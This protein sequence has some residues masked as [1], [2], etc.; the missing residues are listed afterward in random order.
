[1]RLN[2]ENH[3]RPK[4]ASSLVFGNSVFACKGCPP[5]VAN[6]EQNVDLKRAI[7]DPYRNIYGPFTEDFE[8]CTIK[9]P[10]SILLLTDKPE[11]KPV[12]RNGGPT[13]RFDINYKINK[14]SDNL[15]LEYFLSGVYEHFYHQIEKNCVKLT[16]FMTGSVID[17]KQKMVKIS[18]LTPTLSKIRGT[19]DYFSKILSDTL[20]YALHCGTLACSVSVE[21][22]PDENFL[23]REIIHLQNH[24]CVLIKDNEMF[25]HENHTRSQPCSA[26]CEDI[27]L[28]D[29]LKSNRMTSC[30]LESLKYLKLTSDYYNKM[31]NTLTYQI[32]RLEELRAQHYTSILQFPVDQ[33]PLIRM[34]IWPK[35]FEY[36]N[37]KLSCDD[38]LCYEDLQKLQQSVGKIVTTAS[39]RYSF[40]EMGFDEADAQKLESLVAQHQ[41]SS[42]FGV[43]PS[44]LNMLQQPTTMDLQTSSQLNEKIY[45]TSKMMEVK[46]YFINHVNEQ[47]QTVFNE[48]SE[49]S[50]DDLLE[51]IERHKDFKIQL[52]GKSL[53][54]RLPSLQQFTVTVDDIF[55]SLLNVEKFS[56]L[57]CL[58]H[59]SISMCRLVKDRRFVYKRPLLRDCTIIP[60]NPFILLAT[61]SRSFVNVIGGNHLSEVRKTVNVA[62]SNDEELLPF[63]ADHTEVN[64]NMIYFLLNGRTTK[65]MKRSHLPVYVN[66]LKTRNNTF[67]KSIDTDPSRHYQD[68]VSGDYF[69]RIPDIYEKYLSR[70]DNTSLTFMQFCMY[71]SN[72]SPS[73]EDTP[74]QES[75]STQDSNVIVATVN[76]D[77]ELLADS[78]QLENGGVLLKN[79]KPKLITYKTPSKYTMEYKSLMV[80]MY[81]AHKS[82]ADVDGDEIIEKLFYEK[83]DCN[84]TLT[85]LEIIQKK[86]YPCYN[87]SISDSIFI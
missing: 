75:M 22:T 66:P 64:L 83:V 69:E 33:D 84:Q 42:S 86:L 15:E 51:V 20:F 44:N 6:G 49:M 54:V 29:Y 82:S 26:N 59:R 31:F 48:D 12:F 56:L 63:L 1:M 55:E 34:L 62:S 21:L 46:D 81:Y 25:V 9:F 58:Y 80:L 61:R 18:P 68:V 78:I 11:T 39:R 65:I 74:S 36:F 5:D 32:M 7:L 30:Q 77:Q 35:E 3:F 10:P 40:L 27:K 38:W 13:S 57:S 24:A 23:W 76:H 60:Y 47:P 73:P 17:E 41:V 16:N 43:M 67:K 8:K 53:L 37:K 52:D 79:K 4:G 28:D 45:F 72:A 14:L 71:Y 19:K 85:N 87:N 50:L 2:G 70:V